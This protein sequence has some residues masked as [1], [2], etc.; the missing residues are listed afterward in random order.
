MCLHLPQCYG[1]AG[2]FCNSKF[3]INMKK[4]FLLGAMVFALGMMSSCKSRTA[5]E[6][7][8]EPPFEDTIP[9]IFETDWMYQ[10]GN[11][12]YCSLKLNGVT[13]D[14]ALIDNGCYYPMILPD[15]A[16]ILNLSYTVLHVDTLMAAVVGSAEALSYEHKRC[17]TDSL[18]YTIGHTSIRTDTID[19]TRITELLHKLPCKAV[20]GRDVFER[21]V[22]EIDYRHKYMVLSNHLPETIGEYMA[23]PMEYTN[24]KGCQRHR[25]IKVAGFKLKDGSPA[26]ARAFLDLGNAV[27]TAFDS[28]FLTRVDQHFSQI[29]TASL[30]WF[31]L[32]QIGSAVDSVDFPI[33]H[34]DDSRR[35][36][37]KLPGPRL[38]LSDINSDILLGNNFFSHFNIIFDYKNNMF[39][40]KRND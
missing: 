2:W 25:Y 27:G 31:I 35:T 40:L 37:A 3:S 13:I 6:T 7:A 12:L 30:A 17:V 14:T 15:L 33:G 20:I 19:I 26:S 24:S 29:D 8:I 18:Y 5:E 4:L 16:E 11:G 38:G 34:M 36:V 9:I 32:S 21:Y 10:Y 22:V 23:I 39:Y 1:G 28:V